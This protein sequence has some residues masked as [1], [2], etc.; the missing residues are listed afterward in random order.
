LAYYEKQGLLHTV[1]SNKAPGEIFA[2][3]TGLLDQLGCAPATDT[4]A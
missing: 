4:R 3:L 1:E 2:G